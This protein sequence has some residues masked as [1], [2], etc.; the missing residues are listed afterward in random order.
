MSYRET[1]YTLMTLAQAERFWTYITRCSHGDACTQCC[2]EWQGCRQWRG[3][4]LFSVGN[5]AVGQRRNVATHRL[6]SLFASGEIPTGVHVLHTCDNPPCCNPAHLWRGTKAD[7]ILDM[8]QKG[9][10]LSGDR[11]PAR[12]WPEKLPRG[13]RHGMA[14]LIPAQVLA[15]RA[16]QGT[17]TQQEIARH[18]RI[19][20]YHVS[21]IHRRRNW[22]H[23][24]G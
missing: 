14:R 3:Y 18:F 4:G 7:N 1:I 8:V 5:T 22:K 21:N 15:I 20:P 12:R 13:E 23:L 17:M 11:N 24:P 10:S 16:L 19:S 2:W 9:R 6:M